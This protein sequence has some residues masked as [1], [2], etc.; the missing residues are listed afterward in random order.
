MVS[1]MGVEPQPPS[2]QGE[3]VQSWTK[4]WWSRERREFS[5]EAGREEGGR[6]GG[7]EGDGRSPSRRVN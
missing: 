3:V 1:R 4:F 6:G 5:G 7:R 2:M